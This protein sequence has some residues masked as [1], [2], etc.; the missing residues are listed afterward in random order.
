[1]QV[2]DEHVVSH[3]P[4]LSVFKLLSSLLVLPTAS[5]TPIAGSKSTGKALVKSEA[6]AGEK[7]PKEDKK[8]EEKGDSIKNGPPKEAKN[9]E[10]VGTPSN[11]EISQNPSTDNESDD[12]SDVNE[13]LERLRWILITLQKILLCVAALT[14]LIIV[15]YTAYYINML[16]K[17]YSKNIANEE[18]IKNK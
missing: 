6:S 8:G 11:P 14:L 7:N 4:S 15:I 1:M 3:L 5:A 10:P 12:E 18:Y 17:I 13:D 16:R 9:T 2:S